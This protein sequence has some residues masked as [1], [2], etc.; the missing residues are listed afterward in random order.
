MQ[1]E[2]SKEHQVIPPWSVWPIYA[3]L[4]LIFVRIIF[5]LVECSGG[6]DSSISRQEA[7]AYI[8]DSVPMLLALWLFNVYHP[9]RTGA[10]EMGR[11]MSARFAG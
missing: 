11:T 6:I 3:A 9:G 1:L 2:P 5:R 7:Y 8:L 4:A 10:Q